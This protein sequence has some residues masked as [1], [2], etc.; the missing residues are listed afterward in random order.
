MPPARAADG[1][2]VPAVDVTC[3]LR[4]GRPHL[5]AADS[6]PHLR[7]GQ[8][9]HI[10][11][12][13]GHAQS[14]EPSDRAAARGPRPLLDAPR[15]NRGNGTAT[16]TARQLRELVQQLIS[17]GEW[18]P[19]DLDALVVGAAGQ[20]APRLASLPDGLPVQVLS[21]MRS[22][23][24]LRGA[25]LPRQPHTPGRPSRHGGD[26][27]SGSRPPGV[28]RHTRHPALRP[29]HHLRPQH[30]RPTVACPARA[31]KPSN[32]GPGLP[33]GRK[34]TRPAPRHDVR[35]PNSRPRETTNE[36]ADHPTAPPHRS[37]IKPQP[38]LR[39]LDVPHPHLDSVR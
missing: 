25:V 15:L 4:P 24:I 5:T 18:Q 33:P 21:R 37:K 20:D 1:R 27:V 19:G 13:A 8:N 3:R 26:F 34:D 9:R 35:A 30:I 7:P 11:A 16:V 23:R 12:P 14:S 38:P 29:S 22:G 17:T 31:P 6:V 32:P 2:L 39:R 36:E 10:P 28:P